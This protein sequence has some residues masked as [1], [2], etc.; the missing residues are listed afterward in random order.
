MVEATTREHDIEEIPPPKSDDGAEVKPSAYRK[1]FRCRACL[2]SFRFAPTYPC[3]GFPDYEYWDVVPPHLKTKTQLNE[4]GLKPGPDTKK[5]TVRAYCRYFVGSGRRREE[6]CYSLF[7]ITEAVKKRTPTEAQLAALAKAQIALRTCKKCGFVVAFRTGLEYGICFNCIAE[8]ERKE[9]QA[10]VD[11]VILWA[12]KMLKRKS[13]IVLDTETTGLPGEGELIEI[14]FV[15]RDGNVLFNQLIRP[16]EVIPGETKGD[17]GATHIHGITA[18]M[19]WDAPTF[20]QVWPDLAVQLRGKTVVAYNADF[21]SGML[22]DGIRKVLTLPLVPMPEHPGYYPPKVD[23]FDENG[24]NRN[25]E[26]SGLDYTRK[27]PDCLPEE[28]DRIAWQTALNAYYA[29]RDENDRR[30]D[31]RDKSVSAWLRTMRWNCLMEQYAI[32]CGEWSDYWGGYRWQRMYGGHRALGDAQAALTLLKNIAS[33][34]TGEEE[35]AA[36]VQEAVA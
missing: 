8:E 18:E 17:I 5:P 27:L 13:L 4:M 12:R 21:D 31:V 32:F 7:D 15:D 28:A 35:E 23:P 6:R 25:W 34:H 3:P 36:K 26:S 29:A 1:L 10:E 33:A 22:A 2:R 19:L 24:D 16:A 14:A 9:R 20:A 30:R 11:E